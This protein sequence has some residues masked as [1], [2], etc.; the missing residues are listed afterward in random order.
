M[1]RFAMYSM[2]YID[3]LVWALFI[4]GFTVGFGHCIGMCGPIVISYSLNIKSKKDTWPHVLYNVGRVTT[5]TILGGLMGL[6]GSLTIVTSRFAGIQKGVLILAG[7]MVLI[8]G[9]M[10]SGWLK[11]VQILNSSTWL[12]KRLSKSFGKLTRSKST[13]AYLPMGLLLGLLP[14]GPVYTALLASARAGM[15]ALTP[16]QGFFKGLILMAAFGMGTM[17]ALFVIGKL[18]GVQW[19]KRKDLIYKFGGMLMILVGGYFILQGIMF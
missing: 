8:M 5:Y 18:S 19:I 12:Q 15:D 10:M 2:W 13:I 3:P 6:T 16:V 1:E 14:C 11:N 9:L 4:T 17:P 7:V